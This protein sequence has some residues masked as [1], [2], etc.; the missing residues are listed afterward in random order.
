[1]NSSRTL[2]SASGATNSRNLN[3][4]GP[5]HHHDRF[6]K[7][8]KDWFNTLFK[9]FGRSLRDKLY[10]ASYDIIS[11]NLSSRPLYQLYQVLDFVLLAAFPLNHIYNV[12]LS[13]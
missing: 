11:V 1:M 4:S 9:G 13:A 8:K 7:E 12:S 10:L 6:G 3:F 5:K 2:T